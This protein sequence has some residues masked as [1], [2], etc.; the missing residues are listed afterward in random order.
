MNLC[1][2]LSSLPQRPRTNRCGICIC[3]ASLHLALLP[4]LRAVFVAVCLP[5]LLPL[6]F[7][8]APAPSRLLT[9]V[10]GLHSIC[11]C[12]LHLLRV[13]LPVRESI[14]CAPSAE[15]VQTPDC[16]IPRY[17]ACFDN[18]LGLLERGLT[19][20]HQDLCVRRQ[21]DTLDRYPPRVIPRVADCRFSLQSL[22]LHG[23]VTSTTPG[24]QHCT[25]GRVAAP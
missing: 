21:Q 19:R 12:R 8:F 1:R 6:L 5:S 17:A 4:S 24:T 13:L 2:P 25:A 20:R 3:L 22:T 7:S 15:T 9:L 18:F 10:P 23:K 14:S 16:Q 11:L